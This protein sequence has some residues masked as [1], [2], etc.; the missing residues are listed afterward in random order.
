MQDSDLSAHDKVADEEHI[1]E[2]LGYPEVSWILLY[3]DIVR[4]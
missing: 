4:Y 1:I 2:Y 3:D